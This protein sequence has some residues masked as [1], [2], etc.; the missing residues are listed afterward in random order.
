M[1]LMAAEWVRAL[2]DLAPAQVEAAV[3]EWIREKTKWPKVADIRSLASE[4]PK[5]KL[6][7]TPQRSFLRTYPKWE[8]FLDSLHPW[9][10]SH[11]FSGATLGETPTQLC[12][13]SRFEAD[14][15]SDKWGDQLE[16]YFGAP[17]TF[18]QIRRPDTP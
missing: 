4:K 9:Q 1:G 7:T 17:L 16:H 6:P 5:S 11:W 13:L 10:E 2:E 3:T 14:H 8:S 15:I 12:G 18:A